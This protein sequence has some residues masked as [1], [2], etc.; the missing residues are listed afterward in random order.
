LADELDAGFV[1][2]SEGE[3]VD[4]DGENVVTVV[5]LESNREDDDDDDSDDENDD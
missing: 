4:V 2:T 3:Y 1:V 5:K